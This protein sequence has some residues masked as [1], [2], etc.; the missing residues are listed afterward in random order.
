MENISGLQIGDRV[1]FF[2]ADQEN[3]LATVIGFATGEILPALKD[4]EERF[5]GF[6]NDVYRFAGWAIV[7]NDNGEYCNPDFR[8]VTNGG[9]FVAKLGKNVELVSRRICP[10]DLE[11]LI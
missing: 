1:R 2:I 8:R 11:E 7:K 5:Y 6:S 9:S 10:I 4:I 3:A